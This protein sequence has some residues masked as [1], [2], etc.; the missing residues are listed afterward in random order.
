MHF[1]RCG[2]TGH[3]MVQGIVYVNVTYKNQNVVLPIHIVSEK[4]PTLFGREWLHHY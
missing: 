2:L 3:T 4:G 1:D